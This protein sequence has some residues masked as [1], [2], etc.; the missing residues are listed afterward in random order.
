MTRTASI[1]SQ[2]IDIINPREFKSVVRKHNGDKHSK[3]FTCWDQFVAMMFCQIGQAHSIREI[4]KDL[5]CCLG[6]LNHLGLA[7]AP[8]KSTLSYANIDLGRFIKRCS[9]GFMSAA[10]GS[11]PGASASSVLRTNCCP[12]MLQ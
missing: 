5:A 4:C 8:K 11:H 6:K 3:G 10:K 1:F 12:L 7:K 9:I 2:I